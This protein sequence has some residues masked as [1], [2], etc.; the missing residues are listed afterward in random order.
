MNILNKSNKVLILGA[1]GNLGGQLM[2]KFGNEYCL[3]CWDKED[4][5]LNNF[6]ELKEKIISAR[7]DIIINAA[8]YNAVDKC[9]KDKEEEKRAM[10]LNGEA[11][12]KLADISLEIGAL[13]IHFVSD[14]VFDGKKEKGYKED[15]K[16]NPISVYGKSKEFGEKEILKR[17]QNGL[18]YYLIRTSKL[19]G[20]KSESENSKESFYDLIL[21]LSEEREE[22]NMV[23][24]EEISC[25][26]YT[27]DLARAVLDLV[28]NKYDFGIYHLVNEGASSWYDGAKYLFK[29]KNIKKKLNPISSKDYSRPAE[30]PRYSVL[31]NTKFPKLRSW[32]KALKEYLNN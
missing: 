26:T 14:Y 9:E 23:D 31:I 7:P 22:F 3:I 24:K 19:F 13:F 5:D 27:P 29:L 12:G 4:I 17:A 10:R 11:V 25:F 30:R 2:N 6:D 1:R 20:P 18:K 15:D 16:T 21:R 32:K 8:A 28:G